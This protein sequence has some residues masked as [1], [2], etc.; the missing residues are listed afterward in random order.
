MPVTKKDVE[1]VAELARL[2]FTEK[3]KEELK[4]ELNGGDTEAIKQKMEQLNK[5]L[6]EASTKLYEKAQKEEKQAKDHEIDK[7]GHKKDKVVDA[8][9]VNDKEEN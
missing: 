8:E 1:M 6:H 3:E 4:N 5:K 7:N 2:S 9:V